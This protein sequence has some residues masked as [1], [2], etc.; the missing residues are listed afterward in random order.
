MHLILL[1]PLCLWESKRNLWHCRSWARLFF[2]HE[3]IT[4]V[5]E[6]YVTEKNQETLSKGAHE[7][8]KN[9]AD[10]KMKA[11]LYL[12]RLSEETEVL[13]SQFI[14]Y[15]KEENTTQP[16]GFSELV[17]NFY[18]EILNMECSG[19]DKVIRA[20]LTRRF[21]KLMKKHVIDDPRHQIRL[22]EYLI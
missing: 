2:E 20:S 6:Y 7:S 19:K 11:D 5:S 13:F 3:T 16:H 10:A 18:Y 22:D 21:K 14:K 4:Y 12:K 15:A 8:L 9:Y 17:E 1:M